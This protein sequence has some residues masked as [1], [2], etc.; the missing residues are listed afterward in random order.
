MS[1][2]SNLFPDPEVPENNGRNTELL[3]ALE[4]VIF[5]I[6]E[7]MDTFTEEHRSIITNFKEEIN[8]GIDKRL[9]QLEDRMHMVLIIDKNVNKKRRRSPS[10]TSRSSR[11]M[12]R[13]GSPFDSDKSE[14]FTLEHSGHQKDDDPGTYRA[15]SADI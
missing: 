15:F 7:T 12:L 5:N 1:G 4:T 11:A 14:Q 9:K 6:R 13:S 8:R 10:P 2:T 3:D